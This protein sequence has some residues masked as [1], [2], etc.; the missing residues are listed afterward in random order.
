MR[1]PGALSS[2]ARRAAPRSTTVLRGRGRAPGNA[3]TPARPEALRSPNWPRKRIA[4]ARK[5]CSQR[6]AVPSPSP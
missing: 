2:R 5:P 4:C 3:P 6:A 1:W